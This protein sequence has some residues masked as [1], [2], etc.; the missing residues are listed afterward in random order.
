MVK[1]HNECQYFI[2]FPV[3]ASI[4]TRTQSCDVKSSVCIINKGRLDQFGQLISWVLRA[5]TSKVNFV[6]F[7]KNTFEN[8]N[9]MQGNVDFQVHLQISLSKWVLMHQLGGKLKCFITCRYLF[10]ENGTYQ[11]RA[12]C[13]FCCTLSFD[14]IHVRIISSWM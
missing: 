9:A 8:W 3:W 10:C 6:H 13:T 14:L 4:T 5:Q 7:E 2:V 11:I 1:E 12:R